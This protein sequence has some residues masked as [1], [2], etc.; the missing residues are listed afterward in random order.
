[1]YF[2][3]HTIVQVRINLAVRESGGTLKKSL[4]KDPKG[5]QFLNNKR[6]EF[7]VLVFDPKNVDAYFVS[8]PYPTGKGLDGRLLCIAFLNFR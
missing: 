6:E 3:I 2:Q 7:C 1:M 4:D 5:N 8:F